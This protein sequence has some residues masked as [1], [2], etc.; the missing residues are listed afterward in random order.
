MCRSLYFSSRNDSCMVIYLVELSTGN[1]FAVQYWPMKN[2][3]LCYMP[4][5]DGSSPSS[6]RGEDVPIRATEKAQTIGI[7]SH[8]QPVWNRTEYSNGD[9]S[10][11]KLS[12]TYSKSLAELT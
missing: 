9:L 4:A 7:I 1:Y 8:A 3:T 6:S 2:E 11:L 12:F 5:S 10:S